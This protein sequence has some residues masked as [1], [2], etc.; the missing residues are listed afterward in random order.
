MKIIIAGGPRCGKSTLARTLGC[1]H[2]WATD[3]LLDTFFERYAPGTMHK[4]ADEI[5]HWM[6]RPGPWVIEGCPTIL[7]IREWLHLTRQKPC[8][9]LIWLDTPYEEL[10]PARRQLLRM[11]D[12]TFQDT[13]EWLHRLGVKIECPQL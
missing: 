10:N 3:W 4:L 8:D 6:A 13:H 7:A 11:C 2:V 5:V 9:K 1:P 12:A